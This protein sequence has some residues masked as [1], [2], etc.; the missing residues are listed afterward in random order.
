MTHLQINSLSW[1][2]ISIRNEKYLAHKERPAHILTHTPWASNHQ[3][4]VRLN[5]CV[6]GGARRPRQMGE[7]TRDKISFLTGCET[8]QLFCERLSY[9]V[10]LR[11]SEHK[12]LRWH[13]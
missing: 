4:E 9:E 5:G 2:V 1:T 11:V 3:R 6:S 7:G 12:T 8:L 10:G 13:R